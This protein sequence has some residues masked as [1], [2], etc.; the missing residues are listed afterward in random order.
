[1]SEYSWNCAKGKAKAA[2]N[3]KK[4]VVGKR[5]IHV[6]TAFWLV[7]KGYMNPLYKKGKVLEENEGGRQRSQQNA[8]SS[9]CLIAKQLEN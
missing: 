2:E 9:S 1:L 6:S 8:A 7:R 4:T 3:P 5:E